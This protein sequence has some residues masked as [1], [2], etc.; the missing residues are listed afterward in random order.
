MQV[1]NKGSFG[2]SI[3]G[4]EFSLVSEENWFCWKEIVPPKTSQCSE[5]HVYGES[6]PNPDE[7]MMRGKG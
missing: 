6:D 7:S 4:K 3:S 2:T 1:L 5:A